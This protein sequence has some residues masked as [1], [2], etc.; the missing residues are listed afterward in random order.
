MN[1]YCLWYHGDHYRNNN[2]G[3][4]SSPLQVCGD[5]ISFCAPLGDITRGFDAA[6][7]ATEVYGDSE[8]SLEGGFNVG[9]FT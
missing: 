4:A 8:G 2:N 7:C 5:K 6:V 3:R 9:R 1:I